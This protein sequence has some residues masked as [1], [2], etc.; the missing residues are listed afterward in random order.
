MIY[1]FIL[2]LLLTI[3]YYYKI[4]EEPLHPDSGEFIYP[5]IIKRKGHSKVILQRKIGDKYKPASLSYDT[6][7]PAPV[8]SIGP[9]REYIGAFP[10]FRD[11]MF[12]WW[13]FEMLFTWLPLKPKQFR[14]INCLLI[15]VISNLFFILLMQQINFYH[16]LMWT[17]IFQLTIMMPHFDFYQIHAEE[18]GILLL[19]GGTALI[20]GGFLSMLA[21]ILFGLLLVLIFFFIKITFAPTLLYFFLAPLII[22]GKPEFFLV[23]LIAILCFTAGLMLFWT[24]TGQIKPVFWSINPFHL[25]KYKKSATTTR[26]VK[27]AERP[28][29]LIYFLKQYKMELITGLLFIISG[30]QWLISAQP[31]TLT[32]IFMIGWVCVSLMEIVIQGKLYPA[33]L[34]PLVIPGLF[35]IALQDNFLQLPVA[36]MLLLI[37]SKYFIYSSQPLTEKYGIQSQNPF[38][39]TMLAYDHIAQFIRSNSA[40]EDTILTLGYCSPLYALSGRRG[41]LGLYEAL[42]TLE[43]VDISKKLGLYWEW[44][45]ILAMM[46]RHPKLII[47]SS[48]LL[49]VAEL[50]KATAIK[51]KLI[52]K[53]GDYHIYTA[54]YTNLNRYP[55]NLGEKLFK[56]MKRSK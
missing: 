38:V 47:D 43:P 32:E 23:S 17:L 46:D 19:L 2:S 49:N 54:D 7:P 34:L 5:G 25:V 3:F 20:L 18:W 1:F 35:F 27:D 11:K 21:P 56:R 6:F 15:F 42:T 12:V 24:M 50:E 37:W 29:S 4:I 51:T 48:Q 30:L 14:L 55:N 53:T 40:E 39:K 9:E 22:F 26:T 52:K 31:A 13:F 33:H 44:W 45:L 41:A 16:A 28:F 10:A 8:S 36:V